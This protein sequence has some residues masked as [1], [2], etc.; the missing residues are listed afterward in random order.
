[1]NGWGACDNVQD[2][3]ESTVND[4]IDWVRLE[5]DLANKHVSKNICQSCEL[6]IPLERMLAVKGCEYCVSCQSIIDGNNKHVSYYNR[7]G[8]KDSQLR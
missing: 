8:S 1:M 3:I 6:S 5:L 4:A 7:R 2:T